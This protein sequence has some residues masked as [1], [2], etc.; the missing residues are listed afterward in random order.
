MRFQ[1][2]FEA[3]PDRPRVDAAIPRELGIHSAIPMV[4]GDDDLPA[5]VARD[6]D[7]QLQIAL[8]TNLPKRGSFVVMVGGSS[9]GKTRSLGRS[10]TGATTC[11]ASRAV[12]ALAAAS[13]GAVTG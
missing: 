7:S 5:Y 1:D 9:T 2:D 11:S 3:S 13:S 6:F 8:A 10:C 4:G 12:A